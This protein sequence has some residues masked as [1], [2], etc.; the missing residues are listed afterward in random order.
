MVPTSDSHETSQQ[1]Q[2]SPP[3]G[4]ARPIGARVAFILVVAGL[5]AVIGF[6][7]WQGTLRARGNAPAAVQ[8]ATAGKGMVTLAVDGMSC[9]GCVGAVAS[10]LEEVPGVAEVTVDYEHRLARIRLADENVAPATLVAAIEE[11]GYKARVEP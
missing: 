5:V 2:P 4:G 1:Q 11:A 7:T 10:T 9:V 3:P 8:G 6:V